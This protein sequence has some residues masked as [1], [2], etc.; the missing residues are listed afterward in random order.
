MKSIVIRLLACAFV[1]A[2]VPQPLNYW[3]RVA[4]G[5]VN[6]DNTGQFKFA[7]PNAAGEQRS[8]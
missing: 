5:T 1:H 8:G 2:Q 3:G 4:V 7:L 6:F